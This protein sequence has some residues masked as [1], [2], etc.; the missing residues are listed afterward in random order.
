MKWEQGRKGSL[1]MKKK[2]FQLRN[3]LDCYLIKYPVGSVLENHTDPVTGK[4]HYR[5]NII[6]QKAKLGGKLYLNNCLCRKRVI[7]FRP[8]AVEHRVSEVV[9][10]TR[11]VLSIGFAWKN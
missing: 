4:S 7:L 11:Y 10:G 5:L 1:Y 8:D 9:Y 6:L 3:T 2:L